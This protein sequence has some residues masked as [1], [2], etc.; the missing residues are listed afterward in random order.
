MSQVVAL[1]RR[2]GDQLAPQRLAAVVAAAFI[3][4]LSV[5]P[6]VELPPIHAGARLRTQVK[7]IL[8]TKH[9]ERA[10]VFGGL[11]VNMDYAG[12]WAAYPPN[13]WPDLRDDLLY[14]RI[15]G[16][17]DGFERAQALWRE[18]FSD[19]PAFI[20]D[21]REGADGLVPFDDFVSKELT[22]HSTVR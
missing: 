14:L 19:R 17:P 22:A 16:T 3:V 12:T 21:P 10:V 5:F 11:M 20:W 8:S 15:P 18:R 7:D 1:L 4:A 2:L 13:P 9:I 6:R